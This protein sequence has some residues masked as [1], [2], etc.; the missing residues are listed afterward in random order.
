M[1]KVFMLSECSF[2][3]WSESQKV[4]IKSPNKMK[5]INIKITLK[6]RGDI[7]HTTKGISEGLR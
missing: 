4:K 3:E 5:T 7:S 2:I 1:K 6:I